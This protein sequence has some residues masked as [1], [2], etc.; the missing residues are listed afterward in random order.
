MFIRGATWCSF[1]GMSKLLMSLELH[2]FL[3]FSAVKE[4][5]GKKWPISKVLSG[6][7]NLGEVTSILFYV[8]DT[9]LPVIWLLIWFPYLVVLVF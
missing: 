1:N 5:F 6:I 3:F 2:F 7:N 4:R 8:R 9:H